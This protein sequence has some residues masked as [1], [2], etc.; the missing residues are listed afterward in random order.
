[1]QRSNAETH[2]SQT[3]RCKLTLILVLVMRVAILLAGQL[4]SR[5]ISLGKCIF[6]AHKIGISLPKSPYLMIKQ[7]PAGIS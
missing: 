4:Q 3:Y 7:P 5:R 1:M 2:I 6:I